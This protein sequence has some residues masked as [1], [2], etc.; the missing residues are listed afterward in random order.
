MA[1]RKHVYNSQTAQNRGYSHV[2]LEHE[3]ETIVTRQD[4]DVNFV[5][6]TPLAAETV[7]TTH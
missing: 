2:Y 6:R 7:I 4:D 1:H 3:E 5:C